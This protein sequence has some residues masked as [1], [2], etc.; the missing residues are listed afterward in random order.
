MLKVMENCSLEEDLLFND[1]LSTPSLND[2]FALLPGSTINNDSFNMLPSNMSDTL[3]ALT[4]C[5]IGSATLN[6]IADNSNLDSFLSTFTSV[7]MW[8]LTSY[9]Q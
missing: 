2:S 8:M 3:G 7:I 4:E 9:K 1:T 6:T 5:T